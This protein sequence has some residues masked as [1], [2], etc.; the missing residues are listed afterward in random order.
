M[1][2]R[3]PGQVGPEVQIQ[4]LRGAF[5]GPGGLLLPLGKNPPHPRTRELP[6]TFCPPINSGLPPFPS[7]MLKKTPNPGSCPFPL[8][9]WLRESQ[10]KAGCVPPPSPG[11][12]S[13]AS[14]PAALLGL[15]SSCLQPAVPA[16]GWQWGG[17]EPRY[18]DV[19]GP[20]VECHPLQ[21]ITKL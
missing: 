8:G 7:W 18:V 3:S 17:E 20:G 19:E 4:L 9:C 10:G 11:A 5:A 1:P 13:P 21:N 16:W 12:C 2:P 15:R 6:L 14:E